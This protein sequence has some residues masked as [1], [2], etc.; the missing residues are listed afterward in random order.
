MHTEERANV[1]EKCVSSSKK[2]AS[3]TE[4]CCYISDKLAMNKIPHASDLP[5]VVI[6]R[7]DCKIARRNAARDG[8]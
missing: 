7:K 5:E 4:K 6:K 3:N 1:S 2:L 8:M